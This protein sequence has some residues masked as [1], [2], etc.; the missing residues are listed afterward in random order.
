MAVL[1]NNVPNPLLPTLLN[2]AERTL[3]AN[4]VDFSAMSGQV[5]MQTYLKF[6]LQEI[7]KSEKNRE[8]EESQEAAKAAA[9]AQAEADAAGIS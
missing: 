3:T 4:G 7:F 6:L 1:T 5:K 2:V 8:F 9:K